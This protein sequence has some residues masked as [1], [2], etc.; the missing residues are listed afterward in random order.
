[1]SSLESRTNTYHEPSTSLFCVN[2][3]ATHLEYSVFNQTRIYHFC[4][5]PCISLID[6]QMK[7]TRSISSALLK[8]CCAHIFLIYHTSNSITEGYK[9]CYGL[10]PINLFWRLVMSQF[11]KILQSARSFFVTAFCTFPR[12]WDYVFRSCSQDLGNYC[13]LSLCAD[14]FIKA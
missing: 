7:I 9:I 1:M 8:L 4:H 11:S 6:L 3:H 2:H 12:D 13:F 14:I 5:S 10:F